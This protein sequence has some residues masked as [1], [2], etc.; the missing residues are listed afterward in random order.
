MGCKKLSTE[1]FEAKFS[2]S[3]AE[4]PFINFA[5]IAPKNHLETSF[6]T[7]K[8]AN[9]AFPQLKEKS[10]NS[11]EV[12]E[13]KRCYKRVFRN[14]VSG[15]RY[16][17]PELGRFITRDP[18]GY[19]DGP[20][21]YAYCRNNPINHIDPLGLREKTKKEKKISTQL[22]GLELRARKTAKTTADPK[23]R[24]A[25]AKKI[26]E[27]RLNY[28]KMIDD[29]KK[30]ESDPKRLNIINKALDKWSK[31]EDGDDKYTLGGGEGKW[32]NKDKCN[33][34]VG[35]VLDESGNDAYIE[36]AGYGRSR[37]PLAG[38]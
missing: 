14:V 28:E 27:A 37:Y 34:F 31:G 35:D 24:D 25:R 30:D 3:K 29:V 8:K 26:G 23:G 38:E 1:Y 12:I 22:K 21:N 13:Q 32:A 7:S 36:N 17:D 6:S 19:P 16:Y 15:S 9:I 4:N 18:S 10:C 33:K 2:I 20:N 5:D 11:R